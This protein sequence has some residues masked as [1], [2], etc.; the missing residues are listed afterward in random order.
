[1]GKIRNT[2]THA[3]ERVLQST[4]ESFSTWMNT[5]SAYRS[6]RQF[7]RLYRGIVMTCIAAI[8][9]DVAKYQPLFSKKDNRTGKLTSTQHEFEKVLERPNPRMTSKFDLLVATQ[10][11]LEL[12]GNAYWY[13]SVE[14]RSRKV[15]E[16]YL[17]RPDRVKVAIDK[18]TGDV[19]GYTFRNDDGTELPL[20]VDEVQHFKTFNPEN[21]YY[22]LGTVEAGVIYIETEEDSSVFQRNFIKNQASPSGILTIN[23]KIEKEQFNK[24]KAAW[25]EKTEGLANV[26]KTLFIRGADASFTKIGL[27]LG[28]LDMEKLKSITEDKIFKMFRIPKIILGDT[29]Q[30]GLG[31]GN[32]ETADYVFAKRNIDPKQMRIDDGVQNIVRRN[33]KDEAIIVDHVSQIPEDVDRQLNEDDKLV[34]RVMTVN[35]IRI[36][37][38]LPTVKGGDQLYVGFNMTPID[39]AGTDNSTSTGKKVRVLT[40]AKKD[41]TESGFFR[42][43]D[44]I[45]NRTVKTYES[46]FKKDLAAQ[47]AKVIDGL[48]A[49]AASVTNG[50]GTDAIAKAYEEIMP[51]GTEE[52][53]KS[54]EWLIPLML[55]A[56]SQG[57]EA[58]LALIDVNE[59][60]NISTAAKNAA[61]TAA[62]RVVREFTQQTVDKLKSEIAAGVNAGESLADLTKRVN[63]VYADAKGWRTDRLSDSESHKGVN[64]GVQLGFEQGGVKHK[65]WK[66]LGAKP[67][68][69]CRAMDGTIIEVRKP[70]VPK[71]GTLVGDDGSEMVQDYDAVENAHAHANCNCWLF[72]AD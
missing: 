47:Q 16:I 60:P 37:K 4:G 7:L 62:K 32:A 54:A 3:V 17:M 68:A 42:Q 2:I 51:T 38:G 58:A 46:K 29:D 21:E 11:F 52:A 57:A 67:C 44:S 10:S 61:E 13:L 1:M 14:E 31:R 9:E 69:F 20:D 28:D 33:Y 5:Y 18:K 49:Y 72:P 22:G 6:R 43:L 19:I 66:T 15:H 25:K 8:A 65:I 48:A 63:K 30:A 23:G 40:V 36:R 41:A 53:D 64:K 55:L 24:V 56:L 27:S 59:D 34:N 12:V 26:G 35:E 50:A 45:K 71:G 39:Q 70:F